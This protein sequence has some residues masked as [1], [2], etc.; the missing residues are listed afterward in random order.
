[1]EPS[2][3]DCGE[4]CGPKPDRGRE[5]RKKGDE[6]DTHFDNETTDGLGVHV[7]AHVL[8]RTPRHLRTPTSSNASKIRPGPGIPPGYIVPI[9]KRSPPHRLRASF[10]A[11]HVDPIALWG[12]ASRSSIFLGRIDPR[13]LLTAKGGEREQ[14]DARSAH[15]G[16]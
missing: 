8:Q 2:G 11:F 1:M 6:R 16:A 9:A 5:T 3:L 4:S 10:H 12:S 14:R 13:V 15:A 7:V